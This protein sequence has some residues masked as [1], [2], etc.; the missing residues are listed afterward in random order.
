VKDFQAKLEEYL[1]TRKES[2]LADIAREKALTDGI[3]SD[4]KSALED[5]SKTYK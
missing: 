4:L 3:V 5:F 2:L 1:T